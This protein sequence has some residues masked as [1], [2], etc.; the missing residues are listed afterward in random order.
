VPIEYSTISNAIK[1]SVANGDTAD[2]VFILKGTFEEHGISIDKP[3]L[4][5]GSGIDST[6]I[7][8]NAIPPR[9]FT[10][11][12]LNSGDTIFA[13]YFTIRNGI[14]TTD[15]YDRTAGGWVINTISGEIILDS[16]KFEAC[17]SRYGGGAVSLYQGYLRINHCYFIDNVANPYL[18]GALD[19]RDVDNGLTIKNSRF[20][21]NRGYYGGAIKLYGK[22]GNVIENCIFENNYAGN[23]SGAIDAR[24]SNTNRIFNCTFYSNISE[25]RGGAMSNTMGSSTTWL[26]N[27]FWDDSCS[28][29]GDE[30]Y[31]ENTTYHLLYCD[32][33]TNKIYGK[34]YINSMIGIIDTIPYFVDDENND[35]HLT[36]SSYCI[37][38][39]R[40]TLNAPDE[41][42][43]GNVRPDSSEYDIGAYEYYYG[44]YSRSIGKWY[45]PPEIIAQAVELG[46][47][48]PNPFNSSITIEFKVNRECEVNISIHSLDGKTIKHLLKRVIPVGVWQTTWNGIDDFKNEMPSGVYLVVLNIGDNKIESQKISLVR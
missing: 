6:V 20:T 24:N 29:S 4:I 27:I 12:T 21:N 11:N 7:D 23:W 22:D 43:D 40:D 19:A 3:I 48:H 32:I 18:S 44:A 35:L 2:T 15:L 30:L 34:G 33:D 9:I 25:T 38:T 36:D 39:G 31:L 41:D 46:S 47:V 8:G 16:V 5:A 28:G 37:N 42:F 10:T 45:K 1:N 26:N 14:D 17:S 13:R